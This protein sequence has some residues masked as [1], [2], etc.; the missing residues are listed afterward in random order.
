[1]YQFFQKHNIFNLVYFYEHEKPE[2]P[3]NNPNHQFLSE[4]SLLGHEIF[5]NSSQL[6]IS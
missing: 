4:D 5:D 3:T 6:I 2:I 1:M